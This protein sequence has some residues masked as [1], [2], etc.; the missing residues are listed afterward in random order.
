MVKR[1]HLLRDAAVFCA[2]LAVLNWSVQAVRQYVVFDAPR[3]WPLSI[4]NPR[5]PSAADMVT[6]VAVALGFA[7]GLAFLER[8]RYRSALGITV[9]GILL[10]LGSNAVQGVRAG[11]VTPIS[12][13]AIQYYSDAQR[14]PLASAEFLREF[15]QIQPTLGDHGRTHPP[16]AILLFQGLI[17]LTQDQPAV[18]AV[19]IAVTAAALT[20]IFFRSFLATV[21]PRFPAGEGIFLLLLLPA[22]Q[23]YYC[24]SLDALIAALLLGAVTLYAAP[25]T[26]PRLIGAVLC[27]L[28][29]SFLTFGFVWAVPLLLVTEACRWEARR[30]AAR[31]CGL[32]AGLISFY[33]ALYAAFDFSYVAALRTATRLENPEGFRLF[34]EPVSYLFTRLEDVCE[35]VVFFGPFLLALT[36]GGW[37]ALSRENLLAGRMC[38]T[39]MGMLALL[40][41]T[42][43]YRTGE[44]ARACLF[45]Y[46]YLL[47][48]AL[49][50]LPSDPAQRRV[51]Y[52]LVFAQAL[53][54]Q[55]LGR[56]F[57]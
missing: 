56:F 43:A 2:V 46:P 20:A 12:G 39:A 7:V 23:I 6:A 55:L 16:G 52:G 35:I 22:V 24:A 11:F 3:W 21:L 32:G 29:A 42:G 49:A 30:S 37:R 40:F 45:V 4:F 34:A 10:I 18:I 13:N 26:P 53:L 44:T 41:L 57:W 8:T 9:T 15:H 31:L 1:G 27:L 48:P 33:L 25:P 47:L 51:W 50:A 5:M 19:L 38:A 14:H 28:T 17:R 36:R 54:M